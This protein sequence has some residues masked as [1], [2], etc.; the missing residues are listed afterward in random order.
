MVVEAVGTALLSTV[1]TQVRSFAV[2]AVWPGYRMP[3]SEV[4]PALDE[5]SLSCTSSSR[6]FSPMVTSVVEV[7]TLSFWSTTVCVL[8]PRIEQVAGIVMPAER[9]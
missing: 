8:K 6:V 3:T 2:C 1:S 4:A 9:L 5:V 7:V